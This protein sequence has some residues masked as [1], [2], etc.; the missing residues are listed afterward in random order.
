MN[1]DKQILVIDDDAAV[2]DA[3]LLAIR[4]LGFSVETCAS[5]DGALRVLDTVQPD[6][7]FLDLRMPGKSGADF[8]L[9]DQA[10][11]L[12]CPIYVVT[13]FLPD[14]FDELQRARAAGADFDV[15][16]KPVAREKIQEVTRGALLS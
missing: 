12:G 9:S 11:Q 7:V 3:F 15:L 1:P 5:V 2:R 16:A 6:L 10:L 8:L 13:A 14:Y 4:P